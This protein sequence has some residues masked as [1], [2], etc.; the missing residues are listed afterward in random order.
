[1][2][3]YLQQLLDNLVSS[4]ELLFVAAIACGVL[5]AFYGAS[6][7]FAGPS[8]EA[9]RIAAGGIRRSDS[10]DFDLVRGDDND[11]NGLLKAFVPT[12]ES[13][14][15]KVRLQLRKAGIQRRDAVLIYYTV[16]AAL[17]FALPT[18][19]LLARQLPPDFLSK[20]GLDDYLL[21]M[22]L[23]TTLYIVTGLAL[24][25]FYLPTLWL[26][27]KIADRKQRIWET[28][29]NALDL[30]QVSVEAGLGFDAAIV[31]VSNELAT[32]APDI[33]AE[34]MMLQLE[35]QAGKDRQKAFLDMAERTDVDAMASFANVILQASQFGS[36]IT[37]ALNTY[38]EEMRLQ[39]ELIA[40]EK[41]NRLPVQ[42][43]AVLAVMMMPALLLICLSPMVIRWI[44]VFG[45]N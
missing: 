33:S 4:P 29:P 21:G 31:R 27:Q 16:R 44:R 40:Q 6:Q 43:S 20:Y 25:G 24:L 35:I 14:R 34:F 10:A 41:A 45:V 19:F 2:E 30:L 42:M 15:A 37:Q 23:S 36:S 32:A 18:L 9:K 11:K 12:T 22:G 8:A 38:A 39:R 1:M 13:E 28:M 17:G 7:A 3:Q 5:L 26:R